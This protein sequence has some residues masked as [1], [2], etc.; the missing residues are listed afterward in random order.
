MRTRNLRLI[1]ALALVAA[2]AAVPARAAG[3]HDRSSPAREGFSFLWAWLAE[4]LPFQSIVA[5]NCDQSI[6]IDPD[7]HCRAGLFAGPGSDTSD[8][9]A[10][11]DPDG[12]AAPD[13][14]LHIDPD[15]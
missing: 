8:Q 13:Q 10:H 9:S 1:A 7:G 12:S 14:S 15:G 5:A 6:F 3:T 4:R 2:L 11:M